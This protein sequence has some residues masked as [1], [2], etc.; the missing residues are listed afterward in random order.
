MD[1]KFRLVFRGE[2]LDGQHRAVVKRRLAERLKLDDGQIEKLFSGDSV[3]VKRDADRE[4]AARYQSVFKQAGCVLRV[5]ALEPNAPGRAP[6]PERPADNPADGTERRGQALTSA[7]LKAIRPAANPDVAAPDLTVQTAYFPPP[8]AAAPEIRAPA[9]D[10]AEVGALLKE[11]VDQPRSQVVEVH[12]ELAEVGADL[13]EH[14]RE[15]T[16]VEL[17]PL[18]FELAEVGADLGPRSPAPDVAAPDISHLALVE[19]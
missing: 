16:A 18:D 4:T 6:V 1:E 11:P 10:I 2:L 13:L 3:V 8:A 9:Y 7:Q 12:F 19:A 17:G 5:Q 14:P 15:V